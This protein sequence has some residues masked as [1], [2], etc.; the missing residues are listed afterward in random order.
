MNRGPH[1][2]KARL[3]SVFVSAQ[4][5]RAERGPAAPRASRAVREPTHDSRSPRRARPT[6]DRLFPSKSLI[7]EHV[8]GELSSSAVYTILGIPTPFYTPCC[9]LCAGVA[10]PSPT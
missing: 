3:H 2:G 1:L 8:G 9:W 4:P 7:P 6:G 10:L 5:Q